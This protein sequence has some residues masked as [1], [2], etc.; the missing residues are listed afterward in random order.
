VVLLLAIT[1]GRDVDR[2]SR[3]GDPTATGSSD[4]IR[5]PALPATSEVSSFVE[6]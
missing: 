2:V 6:I 3:K 1:R 4:E 5:P